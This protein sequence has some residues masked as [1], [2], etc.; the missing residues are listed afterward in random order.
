MRGV[1]RRGAP[2]IADETRDVDFDEGEVVEV[3]A[4]GPDAC[5]VAWSVRRPQLG[6]LRA[7]PR[8]HDYDHRNAIRQR[9]YAA[10]AIELRLYGRIPIHLLSGVCSPFGGLAPAL[11]LQGSHPAAVKERLGV[12]L[13]CSPA[14]VASSS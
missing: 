4:P 5:D 11:L 10:E 13:R 6:L 1:V 9:Q 2:G 7:V 12:R 14:S 3:E 8:T